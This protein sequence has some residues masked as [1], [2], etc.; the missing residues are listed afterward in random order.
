MAGLIRPNLHQIVKVLPAVESDAPPGRKT[1]V[2]AFHERSG[3][4]MRCQIWDDQR[5]VGVVP[6]TFDDMG[7]PTDAL[8]NPTQV[9]RVTRV[10]FIY[11]GAV[12][13]HPLVGL[14]E[15]PIIIKPG[16]PLHLDLRHLK[17]FDK[18]G[19]EVL[20]AGKAAK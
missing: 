18:F 11:G 14:N 1:R 4:P 6:V 13:A 9:E 10:A 2:P 12:Y 17:L 15:P 3:A 19:K 5:L 20:K 16:N 7:H 8:F